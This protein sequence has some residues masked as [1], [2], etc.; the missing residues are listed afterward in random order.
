M[1]IAIISSVYEQTPPLRYGGIE[2]V[3]DFLVKGLKTKGHDVTLF[4]TGDSSS[5]C[6]LVHFFDHPVVPY[7]PNAQIIHSQK[8]CRYINEHNFDIVHNNV[9][10]S[11]GLKDLL[12]VPMVHSIHCI[13]MY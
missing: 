2:R 7:E 9:D 4:A 12:K 6:N 13:W 10:I 8:A 1:K 5:P 11:V 3:L